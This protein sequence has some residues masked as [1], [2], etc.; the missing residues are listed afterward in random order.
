VEGIGSIKLECGIQ[1][2]LRG[3]T[4]DAGLPQVGASATAKGL[5]TQSVEQAL[6]SS[7]FRKNCG[8]KPVRLVFNFVFGE[9]LDPKNLPQT[10]SFG[11][12]NQFWISVPGMTIQ[13]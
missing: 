2:L 13:P 6:R 10:I 4:A 1:R 7:A 12:P 5:F 8:G 11:Y 3:T 9:A